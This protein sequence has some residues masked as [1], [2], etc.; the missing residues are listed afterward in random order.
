MLKPAI[1]L[2]SFFL[3]SRCSSIN[4]QEKK[5]PEGSTIHSSGQNLSDRIIPPKG[6]AREKVD[7]LSFAEY[8][9]NLK[10]KT[11]GSNVNLYNGEAKGWQNVHVA[12]IDMEIGKK[13]LQQ[14]ADACIR[15]RAEYLWK[16]RK[17]DQIHFH[18]TNG[19]DMEYNRW[20]AGERLIVSGNKTSWSKTSSPSNSYE[21]FR[22]YLDKVFMY[23]GTLSV[24]KE[25]KQ[26]PLSEVAPGDIFIIGGSPGHAVM[27][28]DVAVDKDGKKVFLIAQG[29]MP[30]QDI[31]IIKNPN[32]EYLSPW[33][34]LE[35]GEA[36]QT[37]EWTFTNYKLGAFE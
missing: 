35:P 8:L 9:R 22:A 26:K 5:E 34:S 31:H 13:D 32:D 16:S 14:C 17:Y 12:V 23:A 10:L 18:L 6:F 24:E 15:L 28:A 37:L 7:S 36:L 19:F 4:S 3:F 27:V 20:R 11:N 21:T 2:C 33:F 1:L 25:I 29:Y 30:A